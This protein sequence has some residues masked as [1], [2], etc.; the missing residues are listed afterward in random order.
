[1]QGAMDKMSPGAGKRVIDLIKYIREGMRPQNKKL[2][3]AG[4]QKD[5]SPDIGAV[6]IK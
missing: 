4:D 1:M 5:G 6:K 3:G 2:K